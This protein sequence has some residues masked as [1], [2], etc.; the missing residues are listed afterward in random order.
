[1]AMTG[2]T[3][4]KIELNKKSKGF[5]QIKIVCQAVCFHQFPQIAIKLQV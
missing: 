4:T 1:M 5:N 2:M 3:F